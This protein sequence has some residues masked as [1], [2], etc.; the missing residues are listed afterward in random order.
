MRKIFFLCLVAF[1]FLLTSCNDKLMTGFY[2]TGC[3]G[4]TSSS[5]STTEWQEID[6]YMSARV[7]SYNQNVSFEGKS[8][9]EIDKMAADFVEIQ[10]SKIDK[11]YVS[12]LIKSNDT[13]IYG[14]SRRKSG[15]GVSVVKAYV[16]DKDGCTEYKE[17]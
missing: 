10:I 5:A 11:E 13:Y 17:N 1:A 2:I 4:Y 8:V 12:S 7:E 14:I 15:G 9:V 6:N 16:F 3:V